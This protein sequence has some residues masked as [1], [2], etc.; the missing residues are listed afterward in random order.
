MLYGGYFCSWAGDTF[1]TG[2]MTCGRLK[3]SRPDSILVIEGYDSGGGGG[4]ICIW[5]R[6]PKQLV[7]LANSL[8]ADAC[9]LISFKQAGWCYRNAWCLRF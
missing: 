6:P 7:A 2:R 5:H 9:T 1:T 4:Y 8:L 3:V